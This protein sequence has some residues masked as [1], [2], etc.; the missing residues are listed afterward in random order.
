MRDTIANQVKVLASEIILKDS[1]NKEDVNS[2][3]HKAP[4][5]MYKVKELMKSKK[6]DALKSIPLEDKKILMAYV[7]CIRQNVATGE[8]DR[9]NLEDT[10]RTLHG[11]VFDTSDKKN[12]K[13]L[14]KELKKQLGKIGIILK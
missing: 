12:E 8:E 1:L 10:A 13:N 5:L 6:K 2:L 14:E 4:L 7:I 3:K 9:P 11:D